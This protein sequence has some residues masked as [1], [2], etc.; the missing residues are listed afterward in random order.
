M[1]RTPKPPVSAVI[2]A[3][4]TGSVARVVMGAPSGDESGAPT[5][6]AAAAAPT[7]SSSGGQALTDGDGAEVALPQLGESLQDNDAITAAAAA[8][9]ASAALVEEAVS[10]PPS[11]VEA[12]SFTGATGEAPALRRRVVNAGRGSSDG[13]AEGEASG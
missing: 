13:A 12:D 9:I 2:A 4:T 10:S 3:P 7:A 5:L 8:D 6:T 11:P 1:A